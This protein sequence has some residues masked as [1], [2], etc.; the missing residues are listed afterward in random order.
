MDSTNLRSRRGAS[1]A[2]ANLRLA[3]R[4]LR[5]VDANLRSQLARHCR[6][7]LGRR[8][9]RRLDGAQVHPGRERQKRAQHARVVL[10]AHRG[11]DELHR[12]LSDDPGQG[13]RKRPRGVRVVRPVHDDQRLLRNDFQPPR[14]PRGAQSSAHVLR[15]HRYTSFRRDLQQSTRQRRVP[16]LMMSQ[17]C[18]PT[19][20][21]R[22][23]DSLR[24]DDSSRRTSSCRNRL[25]GFP[26]RR[27]SS[28]RDEL[29][30]LFASLD[31]LLL[32]A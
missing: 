13:A 21:A 16:A 17:Q 29:L 7:L 8:R 11:K 15:P 27:A 23:G 6:K 19:R 5:T 24:C 1:I 25:H 4:G 10:V 2:S 31:H 22:P 3:S 18:Q 32:L 20:S 14:P 30:G 12:P 9:A 28:F 26:S